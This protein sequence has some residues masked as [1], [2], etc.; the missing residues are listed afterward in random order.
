MNT[1]YLFVDKNI[2]FHIFEKLRTLN[3]LGIAFTGVKEH[4]CLPW[5]QYIKMW[6]GTTL[7]EIGY[8]SDFTIMKPLTREVAIQ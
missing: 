5:D 3:L 7:N 1:Y 6:L 2:T 8:E 4:A